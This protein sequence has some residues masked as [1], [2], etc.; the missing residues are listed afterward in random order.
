VR[1]PALNKVPPA[2]RYRLAIVKALVRGRELAPRTWWAELDRLEPAD[3]AALKRL[4]ADERT[5]K[6]HSQTIG[7]FPNDIPAPIPYR[8]DRT[9]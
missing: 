3:R 5:W 4:I 2:E 7:R 9:A 8:E 1:L 6:A